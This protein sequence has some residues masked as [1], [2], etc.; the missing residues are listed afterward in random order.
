MANIVIGIKQN[1]LSRLI[2]FLKFWS[3][4]YLTGHA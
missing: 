4:M 1:L 3:Q 2:I